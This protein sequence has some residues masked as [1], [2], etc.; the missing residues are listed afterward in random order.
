MQWICNN[1]HYTLMMHCREESGECLNSA[2]NIGSNEM[3][4]ICNI[5]PRMSVQLTGDS[6]RIVVPSLFCDIEHSRADR[7]KPIRKTTTKHTKRTTAMWLRMQTLFT[8][9]IVPGQMNAFLGEL[10]AAVLWIFTRA[11]LHHFDAF[12]TARLFLAV[13]G[14]HVQLPD[15]ILF[16]R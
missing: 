5:N 6:K 12:A 1:I 15:A 3:S 2:A 11:V 7:L 14:N 9:Q 10:A 16:H 4:N 13:S 8:D